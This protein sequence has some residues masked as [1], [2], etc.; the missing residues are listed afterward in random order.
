MKHRRCSSPWPTR[1]HPA[2]Q[3]SFRLQWVVERKAVCADVQ[4]HTRLLAC[5]LRML[6]RR[7][8][9]EL[10]GGTSLPLNSN[11]PSRKATMLTQRHFVA[12]M[13]GL[14]LAA[15]LGATASAEERRNDGSRHRGSHEDSSQFVSAPACSVPHDGH[16]QFVNDRSPFRGSSRGAYGHIFFAGGGT[17]VPSGN[18][19]ERSVTGASP[20]PGTPSP[21]TPGRPSG[22]AMPVHGGDDPPGP[23]V[24]GHGDGPDGPA[25][26]GDNGLVTGGSGTGGTASRVSPLAVNPEPASLL[27][28][29][30]GLGTIL[31]A[32]RRARKQRH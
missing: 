10:C 30:T 21:T 17:T 29:G 2:E 5:S 11:R 20:S 1:T 18:S 31:L 27:L 25:G 3:F 24:G 22:P 4:A 6:E 16:V 23:S 7:P 32:R 9:E 19:S 15:T 26:H 12:A 14:A 28:V 8:C 13:T